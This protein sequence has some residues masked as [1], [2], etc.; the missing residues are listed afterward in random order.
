MEYASCS[1][2]CLVGLRGQRTEGREL[3]LM[4]RQQQ[5]PGSGGDRKLSGAVEG[6][7]GPSKR[8]CGGG[9]AMGHQEPDARVRYLL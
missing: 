8:E 9:S 4:C 7:A 1:F 3:D 2:W 6:F 5:C